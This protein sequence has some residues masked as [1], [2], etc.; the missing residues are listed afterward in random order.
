MKS[1]VVTGVSTGIG[2]GVTKV[3]I[4]NG[5]RVFGSVRKTQDAE[6]LKAEFGDAFSPLIFDVTDEEKVHA[7]ARQVREALNGET[8]FGLVNNAG[9][10][11]PAPMAHMPIAEFRSQIEINLTGQLIVTQA[12]LP[13]LGMDHSLKG[14]PGRLINMSSTS[15]KRGAPFVGAYV[16]SKHALEGLSET[17]R[18]ELMLYG[19]D[20]IIIGPGAVATPIWDKGEQADL[21]KY[22]HTEYIEA[23][24]KF[25]RYMVEDGRKGLPSE[26]IGEV[27]LHALTTPKPKVRYPVVPNMLKNWILPMLLP[28]RVFDNLIAKGLGFR[29]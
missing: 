16:T 5:F 27:V 11:I 12:F 10:A 1:V 13:L 14:Q 19:I 9:I 21:T 18:I 17:L 24:K 2:W 28:K 8:L 6:R 7:A 20:V 3:L 29:K 26:K 22:E 23:A 4:Q 15:G 25:Q